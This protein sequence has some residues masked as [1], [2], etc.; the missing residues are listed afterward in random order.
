[1]S[2]TATDNVKGMIIVVA[3][4]AII[5]V[6]FSLLI[7]WNLLTSFLFWFVVTPM[8]AIYLPAIVSRNKSH[9]VES[10]MGL[11][12]FYGLMIF[13]IY[14]HYKTDLFKVMIASCLV[15][16]ILISVIAWTRKLITHYER[17]G[18]Q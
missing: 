2:R 1:M 11:I 12:T 6:P 4:L 7:G 9:F 5:L 13:M 14:D 15:N 3:G 8:L 10:S 18:E 17:T 16:L